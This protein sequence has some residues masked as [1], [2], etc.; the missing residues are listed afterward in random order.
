MLEMLSGYKALHKNENGE[1]RLTVDFLVPFIAKDQIHR[2]LDP[3]VPPPTPVGRKAVAH[4]GSLVVACVS[5]KGQD[6]PSMIEIVNNLM[7]V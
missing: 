7:R 1:Q 6:R 4:V 5:L 3:I 2:V